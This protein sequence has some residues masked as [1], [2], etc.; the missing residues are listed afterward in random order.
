MFAAFVRALLALYKLGYTVT[1]LSIGCSMRWCGALR[2]RA[3]S[4]SSASHP[5]QPTASL[6][7]ASDARPNAV[8]LDVS[9]SRSARTKEDRNESASRLRRSPNSERTSA[10]PLPPRYH[11]TQ[12]HTLGSSPPPTRAILQV[13]AHLR[14]RARALIASAAR[15]CLLSTDMDLGSE[16][17]SI[18]LTKHHH[19]VCSDVMRLERLRM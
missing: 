1:H 19:A 16:R 3:V 14:A 9:R 13:C 15:Q 5:P 6:R 12:A 2:D 4:R 17:A 18:A 8:A 7:L 11:R 10:S